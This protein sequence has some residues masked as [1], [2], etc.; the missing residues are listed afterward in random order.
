MVILKLI[1]LENGLSLESKKI[2]VVVYFDEDCQ[3]HGTFGLMVT[4]LSAFRFSTG[5]SLFPMAPIFQISIFNGRFSIQFFQLAFSFYLVFFLFRGV[6]IRSI[7][8]GIFQNFIFTPFLYHICVDFSNFC[9][10]NIDLFSRIPYIN[11]GS[12]WY[13]SV[14]SKKKVKILQQIS[15]NK[16]CV[17]Y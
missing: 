3:P 7:E 1:V 15:K 11:V 8:G 16:K 17:I 2:W 12:K 10:M 9:P 6:Y 14:F 13:K 4:A 5:H